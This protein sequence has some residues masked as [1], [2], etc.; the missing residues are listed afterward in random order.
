MLGFAHE[1]EKAVRGLKLE[2][3]TWRDVA[4]QY[5]EAFEAQT[6]RLHELQDICI[7]TQ[8]ELE[9]ERTE[10]RRRQARSDSTLR[11]G[12]TADVDHLDGCLDSDYEKPSFGTAIIFRP[13]ASN[14]R[15]RPSSCFSRVERFIG[16]C[17]YG[18]ALVEVD[19]LL[20]GPLTSDARVQGLLLKSDILRKSELLYDALAACSEAL[21][22]CDRLEDELRFFTPRIQYQRGL[23]YYQLSMAKQARDAL[24]NVPDDDG[25]LYAKA[26]ELRNSCDEQLSVN[27]RSGFESYRTPSEGYLANSQEA[28]FEAKQ[29]RTSSQVRLHVHKAKRL[30][31]P[32][33][34]VTSRS[35]SCGTN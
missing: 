30:S 7:A 31:L 5:R 32:H 27:R 25:L 18:T 11:S 33:R 15:R 28:S 8:A 6:A 9:N 4:E 16:Q 19:H 21:E 24:S 1:I 29:R 22:L 13:Y 10:H 23:C 12:G 26:V 34:W 35:K 14:T 3:D 2:R 17:D 20:R